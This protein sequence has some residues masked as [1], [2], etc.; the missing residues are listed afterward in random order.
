MMEYQQVTSLLHGSNSEV[1]LLKKVEI[2]VSSIS[3]MVFNYSIVYWCQDTSR[4]NLLVANVYTYI[5]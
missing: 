2:N 3:N 4:L 1:D 5:T